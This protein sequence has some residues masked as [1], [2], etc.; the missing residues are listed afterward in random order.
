MMSYSTIREDDDMG[1]AGGNDPVEVKVSPSS[2]SVMQLAC[3]VSHDTRRKHTI[4]HKIQDMT[5]AK[6]DT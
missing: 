5:S 1:S 3:D 4:C 2:L 6:I